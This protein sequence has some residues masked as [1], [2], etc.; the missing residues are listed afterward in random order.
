M[1]KNSLKYTKNYY[2]LSDKIKLG[3]E[4]IQN[5][6]LKNFENGKYQILNDDVYVN[7][8]DYN[9]KH[10]NQGKWE[11]HRKYIDIQ[12]MIEGS[13]LIGVGEI[14]NFQVQETYDNEKDVEFL[15]SDFPQQFIKMNEGDFIILYPYDVHMPQISVTNSTYVKK[16][17]VKVVVA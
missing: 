12:F 10:E 16:A 13:E 6:N 2:S 3:L 4:F 14:Q 7:I 9:T 8:Q 11:A 15:S 1:I 5:N 17:V